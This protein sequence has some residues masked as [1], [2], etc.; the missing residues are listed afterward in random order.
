MDVRASRRDRDTEFRDF[1]VD[2][3]QR[4]FR[5]ALL[6]TG[7]PGHAQDLVQSTLEKLYVAW[8]RVEEPAAYARRILLNGFIHDRRRARRERELLAVADGAR[9]DRQA[10][11]ALT[12]IEAMRHLPPRMRAVVVLRYWEGES[13]T[14]TSQ[15][16]GMS[17]GTVKSTSA[18]A[19]DRLR[20]LLGDTFDERAPHAQPHQT[21]QEIP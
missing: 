5:Q 1:V 7:E 14:R 9:A 13:V 18:R 15:V 12:V 19:L 17:E 20:Y 4:L 21:R 16:L 8:H 10:D 11:H 6:L 2:G 3:Q